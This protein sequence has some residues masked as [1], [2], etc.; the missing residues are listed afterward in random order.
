[1]YSF[2]QRPDTEARTI[3]AHADTHGWS[4]GILL[5][6]PNHAQVHDEPLYAHYLTL[7]G[8]QRPY[9]D[10]VLQAQSHDGNQVMQTIHTTAPK[11]K[12]RGW[13]VWGYDGV[14]GG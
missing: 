2:L 11:G 10:M 3:H 6:L 4:Q 8:A 12:V 13:R 1:M 7:T 14:G 5:P 9:T